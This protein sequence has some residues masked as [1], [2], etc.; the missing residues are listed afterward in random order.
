MSIWGNQMSWGRGS[1]GTGYE[2]PRAVRTQL[3]GEFHHLSE[4]TVLVWECHE[5]QGVGSEESKVSISTA[6]LRPKYH[7]LTQKKENH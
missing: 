2:V 7:P 1:Q 4:I 3:P 6:I 5:G